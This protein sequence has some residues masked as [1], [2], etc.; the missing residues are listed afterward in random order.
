MFKDYFEDNYK[1]GNEV[2]FLNFH[3]DKIQACR[4]LKGVEYSSN[5]VIK[6]SKVGIC[7]SGFFNYYL[8]GW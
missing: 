6:K 1:L 7:Y 4:T 3:T 5:K 8:L 2:N